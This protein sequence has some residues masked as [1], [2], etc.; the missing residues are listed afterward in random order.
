MAH[1]R[2]V[3][4]RRADKALAAPDSMETK[5][6]RGER[7]Y[8]TGKVTGRRWQ[9]ALKYAALLQSFGRRGPASVQKMMRPGLY[10]K[11]NMTWDCRRARQWWA[12]HEGREQQRIMDARHNGLPEDVGA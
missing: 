4:L 6:D 3:N 2:E 9:R 5:M 10:R 7:R 1:Q 12:R 8:R 11:W